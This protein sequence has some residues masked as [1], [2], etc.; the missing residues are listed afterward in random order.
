M[1]CIPYPFVPD[2][3]PGGR[4]K[5][6]LVLAGCFA[7]IAACLSRGEEALA[8]RRLC[9]GYLCSPPGNLRLVAGDAGPS[10]DAPDWGV[11]G[12]RESPVRS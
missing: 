3:Q 1:T 5:G 12:W 4:R 9:H 8:K 11:S 10:F 7:E 6:Y 2:C